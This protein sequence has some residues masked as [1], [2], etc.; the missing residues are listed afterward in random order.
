MG[1]RTTAIQM[2]RTAGTVRL[3]ILFGVYEEVLSQ[4]LR[5]TVPIGG[6]NCINARVFFFVSRV[7]AHA[8]IFDLPL[9]FFFAAKCRQ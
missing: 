4:W 9:F 7:Q 1:I 5:K 3:C 8:R 2:Q 6:L